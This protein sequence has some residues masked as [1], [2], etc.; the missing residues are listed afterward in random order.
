[1][2]VYP[3]KKGYQ[4][5]FEQNGVSFKRNYPS[6]SKKQAELLEAQI[7]VKLAMGE[8]H[9]PGDDV[10]IIFAKDELR[11]WAR[12]HWARP[13]AAE[14]FLA[15]FE[16]FFGNRRFNEI[17]PLLIE[18]YK[19][20]LRKGTTRRHAPRSE[21][22][23]NRYL[24]VLSRVFWLAVKK[25]IIRDNPVREV[26]RYKEGQGRIRYLTDEEFA[27]LEYALQ[28]QPDYLQ[29][30]VRLAMTTA[31]RWRNLANLRIE[32][33]N[34]AAGLIQLE[35]TKS[36]HALNVPM[37]SQCRTLLLDWIEKKKIKKGWLFA[38]PVTSK[39]YRQLRRSMATL[40]KDAEIEEFTFHCFRHDAISQM[41]DAGVNLPAIAEIAGHRNIQTTMKYAHAKD[42][43]KRQ[44]VEL[45]GQ[46]T[47]K[48]S[49]N[50][51]P[52]RKKGNG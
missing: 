26:S 8:L 48:P 27:R 45:L 21:K 22:T 50:V 15:S 14:N 34:F 2:P 33:C 12:D 17:S 11:K 24:A 52:F 32:E 30:L 1:M 9:K 18:S 42:D 49:D 13:E 46:R 28:F 5:R 41:V 43:T 7:K 51:V 16:S 10:F 35:K 40:L 4:I 20:R 19:Q 37:S 23:V 44:A 31:M 3:L 38:N 39:P 6:L 36:G 29:I 25:K 47:A